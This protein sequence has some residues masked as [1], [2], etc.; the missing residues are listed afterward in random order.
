MSLIGGATVQS[1]MFGFCYTHRGLSNPCMGRLWHMRDSWA[2]KRS[3][4]RIQAPLWQYSCVMYDE[5]TPVVWQKCLRGSLVPVCLGVNMVPAPLPVIPHDRC[6]RGGQ[7]NPLHRRR[8]IHCHEHVL[9]TTDS[10]PD[11]CLQ[12]LHAGDPLD[13]E[14]SEGCMQ[15]GC[16]SFM[17]L[18]GCGAGSPFF[19]ASKVRS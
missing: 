10:W 12:L 13:A 9:Q 2:H 7:H 1:H 14:T 4:P 19:E 15:R 16:T 11:D 6:H 5:G 17:V 3:C 8:L 18:A